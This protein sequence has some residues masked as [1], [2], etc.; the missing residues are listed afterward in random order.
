MKEKINVA[1]I[2]KSNYVFFS[3][4][5]FDTTT[6]Y[7]FI[8]ALKRSQKLNISYFPCEKNFDVTKLKGKFDMILLPNNKT[9]GTPDELYGIKNSTIPVIARTGDPH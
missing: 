5:H 8:H 9:D 6:F 3:E 7:F 2:Y 1:L 4:K